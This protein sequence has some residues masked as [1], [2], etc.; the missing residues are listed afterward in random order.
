MFWRKRV[1]DS[2]GPID[3]SFQYAMDWDF[4]LRAQAAGFKF[5]RL[6]RFLA[7]F[8]IHDA[9]KT[10]ATYA[11]GVREMGILRRRVLGFDPTH[12]QIRRAIAPYLVRAIGLS[13]RLQAGP[14]AVLSSQR[15]P[16]G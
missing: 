13:L 1:W 15:S 16:T 7:C 10:A 11:I 4:I 2:V 12:I 9:Q 8:R 6:P 5:V 14:A 3:E